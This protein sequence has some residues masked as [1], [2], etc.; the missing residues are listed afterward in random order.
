VREGRFSVGQ[1]K[2]FDH[3]LVKTGDSAAVVET[4]PGWGRMAASGLD[5]NHFVLLASS[6]PVHLQLP[7]RLAHIQAKGQ[8]IQVVVVEEAAAAYLLAVHMF[9]RS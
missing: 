4:R 3:F 9:V 5:N 1:D 6:S 7:R 8:G 2:V